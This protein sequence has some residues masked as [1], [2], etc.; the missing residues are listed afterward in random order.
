MGGSVCFATTMYVYVNVIFYLAPNRPVWWW[1]LAGAIW[2]H[3][4]SQ[5]MYDRLRFILAAADASSPAGRTKM[6]VEEAT[7]GG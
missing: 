2:G 4:Q 3:V 7:G 1:G 5:H 6:P